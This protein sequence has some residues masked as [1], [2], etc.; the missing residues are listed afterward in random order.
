MSARSSATA[1]DGVL[2]GTSWRAV[3][4]LIVAGCDWELTGWKDTL[5]IDPGQLVSVAIRLDLVG[6]YV[7]YC[8]I[9]EHEITR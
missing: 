7:Y 8:H 9:I 6:R 2:V 3:L 1:A 5:R 4:G